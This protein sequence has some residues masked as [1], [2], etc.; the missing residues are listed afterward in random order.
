MSAAVTIPGDDVVAFL[1]DVFARR[2]A[3]SYL[4]EAVSMSEHMLQSAALAEAA[5]EPDEV[6]AAALLHDIGHFT[7][8]FAEDAQARGIDSRHE[9]AGARFLATWFPEEVVACV[10]GHVAAKRYLWCTDEAYRRQLSQASI[11]SLAL[12]GGP[13]DEAGCETFA[14]MPHRDAVLRVRRY[15]DAGKQPGRETPDFAH[16][17]PLLRRL[18][19]RHRG[20]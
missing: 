9:V 2:G 8:E 12:Q 3:E 20:G 5:G 6:V 10:A 11:D 4:G 17:V 19:E 16:Y 14:A 13:L 7:H 15:D 18:T 1:A